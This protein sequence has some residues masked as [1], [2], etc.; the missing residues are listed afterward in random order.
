MCRLVLEIFGEVML[1]RF[2]SWFRFL[3]FWFTSPAWFLLVR[4]KQ[5]VYSEMLSQTDM[6]S[7]T[8]SFY[9]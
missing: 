9:T 4:P 5:R 3:G 6:V 1:F 8:N 7:G 2:D